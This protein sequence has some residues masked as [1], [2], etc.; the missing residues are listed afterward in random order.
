MTA[1]PC[2][3]VSKD[4]A[5]FKPN[6]T[7]LSSYQI[8]AHSV[9]DSIGALSAFYYTDWAGSLIDPVALG[10]TITPGPCQV[11]T[12]L[13]EYACVRTVLV[14]PPILGTF[15]V[16]RLDLSQVGG[17]ANA[18]LHWVYES[19]SG[20]G[21]P[22]AVPI[23]GPNLSPIPM[24]NVAAV[25]AQLDAA[26]GPGHVRYAINPANPD[27]AYI[28]GLTAT[29]STDHPSLFWWG[30]Q[31]NYTAKDGLVD[32]AIPVPGPDRVEFRTVELLK[33]VDGINV[34]V[35][36]REKDGTL[37]VPQPAPADWTLGVCQ[38]DIDRVEVC[39]L[40]GEA[41][42]IVARDP[43]TGVVV[44]TRIED[45]DGVAVPGPVI[46]CSCLPAPVPQRAQGFYTGS[47][48][49]E[50]YGP[51][52]GVS[53]YVSCAPVVWDVTVYQNGVTVFTSPSSGPLA[54]GADAVTWF[55]TT[56]AQYATITSFASPY[57]GVTPYTPN[58]MTVPSTAFGE[59]MIVVH[60]TV[61]PACGA[62]P[63]LWHG[64]TNFDANNPTDFTRGSDTFSTTR[65]DPS[66][67]GSFGWNTI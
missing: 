23:P 24:S 26:F 17:Q 56:V 25:Q 46:D 58:M 7:M 57:T 34:T 51:V 60:E 63:E 2:A 5:C 31:A 40:A 15:D 49:V 59:A 64:F 22:G 20:L 30:D 37:I 10:G 66:S 19:V 43:I 6:N 47:G 13:Q 35:E 29:C 45:L 52:G 9:Y 48:V 14:G 62:I 50:G 27:D 41:W 11:P 38:F 54:S 16:K 12:V 65:I 4:I 18:F 39:T 44:W 67:F 33:T 61:D 42:L 8:F 28:Y 1:V 3:Q 32:G 55:N 53:K 21:Y 36:L